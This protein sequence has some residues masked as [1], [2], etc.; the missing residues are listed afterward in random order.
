MVGGQIETR[1]LPVYECRVKNLKGETKVFHAMGL[2]RITGDMSCPLSG[3]QLRELFPGHE[4]VGSLAVSRRPVDFM[5]GMDQSSWLP[6]IYSKFRGRFMDVE[7]LLW[8]VCG[9]Q[10]PVGGSN[11]PEE[12][13]CYVFRPKHSSQ[14]RAPVLARRGSKLS[15]CDSCRQD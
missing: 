14:F 8:E 15:S 6:E 13:Q 2:E 12:L 4:D 1:S 10:A 9:W 11:S 3:A 7:K 5:I